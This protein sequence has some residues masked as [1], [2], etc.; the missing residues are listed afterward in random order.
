MLQWTSSAEK[1]DYVNL[2]LK[3]I[4]GLKTAQWDNFKLLE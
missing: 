2:R 4:Y 1:G 3:I